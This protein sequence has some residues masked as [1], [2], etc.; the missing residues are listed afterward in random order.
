MAKQIGILVDS[1]LKEIRKTDWKRQNM[2]N[3]EWPTVVGDKITAQTR[4]SGIK[5]N[6]LQ[7]EVKSSV[8]LHDLNFKKNRILQKL[9][10]KFPQER[11]RDIFFFTGR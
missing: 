8:F 4:I 9:Q 11:I 7:V 10:E 6:I 5:Q 2:I 3:R 1:F